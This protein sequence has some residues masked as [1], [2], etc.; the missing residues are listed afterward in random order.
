M[1]AEIL[2]MNNQAIALAAD[3]AVTTFG[4]QKIFTSANKLFSLSKFHPVGIMIYG[5]AS[6]MGIPWETPIKMFR[7][8]IGSS[9]FNTLQEYATNFLDFLTSGIISIPEE[10]EKKYIKFSIY[11]YFDYVNDLIRNT[12]K[13]NLDQDKKLSKNDVKKIIADIIQNQYDVW[14]NEKN[15][16]S[17]PTDFN[18]KIIDQN[19]DVIRQGIIDI[20]KKLPLTVKQKQ[21]LT[22]LSGDIFAKFPQKPKKQNISGIVIAGFGKNDIFPSYISYELDGMIN[23]NLKYQ[24]YQQSKIDFNLSARVQA[25]AQSEMVFTFMEG[26]NPDYMDLQNDYLEHILD[27]YSEWVF[28]NLTKNATPAEKRKIQNLMKKLNSTII[29]DY[30]NNLAEYRKNNFSTP[31]TKV[32]TVLPKDELAEMAESLVNI[33]SFKRKISMD[34]ETV[35]GPI[36]VAVISKGDGFIWIK[37]KHYFKPDLNIKFFK[38]YYYQGG[39]ENES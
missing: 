14:T 36:D 5:N 13:K 24:L 33:T 20:F 31:I 25:F 17:I 10:E 4:T 1:T 12:I 37:K 11:M 23:L 6:F 21:Q 3:S 16:P 29:N 32:V 22:K 39:K 19:E 9:E 30:I 38:N 8:S 34:S 7:E 26:I 2:I 15:V 35:G 28:T 27:G 18:Q